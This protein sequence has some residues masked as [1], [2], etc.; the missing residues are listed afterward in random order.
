VENQRKIGEKELKSP[1]KELLY[2][3]GNG[4]LQPHYLGLA[5]STAHHDNH[6][7]LELRGGGPKYEHM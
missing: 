5:E 7:G 6:H 3:L 2:R 4:Q 1:A